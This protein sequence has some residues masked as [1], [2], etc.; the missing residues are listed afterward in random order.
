MF[1]I[2]FLPFISACL[3]ISGGLAHIWRLVYTCAARTV[4]SAHTFHFSACNFSSLCAADTPIKLTIGSFSLTT[5]H[6]RG[7][8]KRPCVNPIVATGRKRKWMKTC[9]RH[10]KLLSNVSAPM[11][12]KCFLANVVCLSA[13]KWKWLHLAYR[14]C[15]KY[16]DVGYMPYAWSMMRPIAIHATASAFYELKPGKDDT[17][18]TVDGMAS[19]LITLQYGTVSRGSKHW[20]LGFWGRFVSWIKTISVHTAFRHF[21]QID[22]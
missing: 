21:G 17:V 18:V 12:L 19:P 3:L 16:G 15:E 1:M 2:T 10:I 5:V 13:W 6:Q 9:F 20:I 14:C 11:H 7:R 4:T 22:A 8:N